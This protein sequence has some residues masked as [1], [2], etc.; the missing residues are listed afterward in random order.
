MSKVRERLLKSAL[1]RTDLLKAVATRF[2]EV[3]RDEVPAFFAENTAAARE[4]QATAFVPTLGKNRK[5]TRDIVGLVVTSE[6]DEGL[7]KQLADDVE[8]S[9]KITARMMRRQVGDPDVDLT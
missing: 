8:T 1:R 9:R 7:R 6:H 3:L 4:K 2:V 5:G